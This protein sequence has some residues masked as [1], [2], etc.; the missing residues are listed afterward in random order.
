MDPIQEILETV[1]LMRQTQLDALKRSRRFIRFGG[2]F[3]VVITVA[4]IIWAW[5]IL[6]HSGNK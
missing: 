5:F 1:R 6:A 4:Y 3:F 2:L